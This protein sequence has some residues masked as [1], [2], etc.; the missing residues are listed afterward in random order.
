MARY[1]GDDWPECKAYRPLPESAHVVLDANVIMDAVLIT[2][3]AAI[4]SLKAL[5]SKGVKFHTSSRA[6]EEVVNRISGFR[7]NMPSI[8]ELAVNFISNNISVHDSSGTCSG[9]SKHDGHIASLASN[10]GACVISEDLPLIYDLNKARINGRTLREILYQYHEHDAS[11]GLIRSFA[12][13]GLGADGHI[14]IKAEA[15][16]DVLKTKREWN[17]FEAK[18]MGRL[19]YDS[20]DMSFKFY[21]YNNDTII[22]LPYRIVPYSIF[23]ASISYSTGF[24]TSYTLRVSELEETSGKH[25]SCERAALIAPPSGRIC[26]LNRYD[27]PEGWKGYMQVGTFGPYRLSSKTWRACQSLIGVAPSTLSADLSFT[28]AI[29][30]QIKGD[31]VFR[32]RWRDVVKLA[33]FSIGGFYPGSRRQQRPDKW[34]GDP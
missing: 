30:V 11:F 33:H 14:F 27:K 31:R 12:G 28:A 25:T 15:H 4:T 10:L 26:W 22:I 29:L 19:A 5:N 20:N 3:G 24:K 2:D 21:G 32:P 8:D 17:L 7:K 1:Y 23:S 13:F 6:V 34:F 9:I 16:E 18:G